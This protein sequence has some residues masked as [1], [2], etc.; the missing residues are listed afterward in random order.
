MEMLLERIGVVS[1][2]QKAIAYGAISL[3]AFLG[4]VD[5]SDQDEDGGYFYN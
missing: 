2:K 1:N 3:S 5:E 4:R